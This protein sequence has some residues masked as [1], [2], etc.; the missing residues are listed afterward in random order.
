MIFQGPWE[1]S[2]ILTGSSFSD[3]SNMGIAGIP[4]GPTG[5]SG[6]PTG[7]QSYVIYAG[8]KHPAEAAKFIQFMS[9]SASQITIA[10]ANHTLPTRQSA[11]SDSGVSSNPVVSGYYAVRS[12]AVSRPVIPQGGQLFT[13]FDPNIQAALAGSKTAADALNAVADKWK[14]LLGQ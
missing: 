2:N 8:T 12:T 1:T 9:S 11:Y 3:Q 7:G 14:T 4:T 5:V 6:S 10:K 13:D